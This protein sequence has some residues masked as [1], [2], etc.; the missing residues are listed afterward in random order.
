MELSNLIYFKTVVEAGSMSKAAQ[1]LFISQPALSTS[2]SKLEAE[3]GIKLFDRSKRTIRL[4]R[5][6]EAYYSKI[7]QVL[8][9]LS[10]AKHNALAA[11]ENSEEVISLA[12]FTYV[13]FSTIIQPFLRIHPSCKFHLWQF[14]SDRVLEGLLNYDLDFCITCSPI[15]SPHVECYHMLIQ[16]LYLTVPPNHS[17]TMKSYVRLEEVRD[18]PFI[19]VNQTSPFYDVTMNCFSLAGFSPKVVCELSTASLMAGMINSGIGIALMPD[20]FSEHTTL[21]RINVSDPK[22]LHNVYFVWLKNREF[23]PVTQSFLDF[24]LDHYKNFPKDEGSV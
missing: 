11:M 20:T 16:K 19:C 4:N 2:I 12:A 1:E 8:N 13:S 24:V 5:A 15:V 6:G 23:T 17:L 10:Q 22:C 9:E 14:D 3:I 21:R 7:V 18:E